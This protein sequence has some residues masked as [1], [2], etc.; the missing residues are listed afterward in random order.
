VSILSVSG[1]NKF[2]G[3]R[4]SMSDRYHSL[5]RETEKPGSVTEMEEEEGKVE[6]TRCYRS[7]MVTCHLARESAECKVVFLD[8]GQDRQV[9]VPQGE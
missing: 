5:K 9:V 6:S 3:N 1:T 8:T 7:I 2:E 4:G